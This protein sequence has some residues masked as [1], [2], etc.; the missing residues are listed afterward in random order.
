M[1]N[2]QLSFSSEQPLIIQ[3]VDYL[4]GVLDDPIGVCMYCNTVVFLFLVDPDDDSIVIQAEEPQYI[5]GDLIYVPASATQ[6]WRNAIGANLEWIWVL[7]NQQ[8]YQDGVQIEYHKPAS[9][10]RGCVQFIAR[11]SS[12]EVRIISKVDTP[13]VSR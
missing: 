10:A 5:S 3:Q 2:W 11:A 4:F 12:L 7:S 13:A 1:K 9:R 6:V 8:G